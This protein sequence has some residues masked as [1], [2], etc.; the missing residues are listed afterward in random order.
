LCHEYR[1]MHSRFMTA[2]FTHHFL[3]AHIP[4]LRVCI[5][6]MSRAPCAYRHF[7]SVI[8]KS[9]RRTQHIVAIGGHVTM[10]LDVLLF[11]KCMNQLQVLRVPQSARSLLSLYAHTPTSTPCLRWS[12]PRIR[13]PWH[14]LC[15]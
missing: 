4:Q 11:G 12:V 10:C 5:H 2:H 9:V 3:R 1:R 14:V 7:A 15:M 13:H 8:V 6:C